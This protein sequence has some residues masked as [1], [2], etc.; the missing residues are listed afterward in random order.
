MKFVIGFIA[1]AVIAGAVFYFN[2]G[3]EEGEFEVEVKSEN[4]LLNLA[5]KDYE[6]KEANLS[7]FEGRNLIVN[8][9]AVWCPFCVDELPAFAALQEEFGDEIVIVA[10][11]RAEPQG[12]VR[13]FTDDLGVTGSLIFW[14]DS[15]DS[16]YRE[17]GGFSMPET[18]FINKDGET[19]FHKRGPMKLDEMRRL[20]KESF[21]K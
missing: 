9:W 10:I 21:N 7:D 8:S 16:F 11:D 4:K 18:L 14:L 2:N 3:G 19:V 13:E 1:L 12:K 15:S 6:G 20:T 17:M 5:F